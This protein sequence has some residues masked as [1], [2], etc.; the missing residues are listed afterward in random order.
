[1]RAQ[2]NARPSRWIGNSSATTDNRSRS[3]PSNSGDS[4]AFSRTPI[5]ALRPSSASRSF[6]NR[7]SDTIAPPLSG[8]AASSATVAN[9]SS[10]VTGLPPSTRMSG[11]HLFL[12]GDVLERL[13]A[14]AAIGVEEALARLAHFQIVVHH[15]LHH[16]RDLM[17]AEARPHD[18]ADARVFR[19]RAAE[20]ELVVLHALLV[21][22]QDADMARMMMPAGIDAAA[23]L[24]LQLTDLLLPH[25]IGELLG[26]VLRNRDRA[27]IGEVAVVQ[28]RARDDVGDQPRIRRGEVQRLQPGKD[29]R[30]V[31]L[32]HMR[33]HQILLV[34][35]AHL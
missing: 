11:I 35:D 24:D 19:A 8:N 22:A 16:V 3:S 15:P 9:V 14:D 1:M 23:D 17:L 32:A 20:L 29:R 13:H 10:A 7:A 18:V 31:A 2:E 6:W 30:Q 5:G 26:D 4:P 21:D 34:A 28:P 25:D 12:I 33:Q 27:R